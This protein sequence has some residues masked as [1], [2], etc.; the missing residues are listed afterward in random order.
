[1]AGEG[2]EV[3]DSRCRL[4]VRLTVAPDPKLSATLAELARA[5]RLAALVA[6]AAPEVVEL[7]LSLPTAL[8]VTAGDDHVPGVVGLIGAVDTGAAATVAGWRRAR[9]GDAI[10]VADVATSRHAA[11]DAGEAGADAILFR[12]APA[13]VRD[14]VA[15][16][17]ELFVLP[18]AAPASLDTMADL[19][20]A[21]ADFLLIEG[22]ELGDRAMP[23]QAIVAALAAAE[24]QRAEAMARPLGE[25]ERR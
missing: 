14:C 19:V 1:M 23:P 24:A 10:L 13:A 9:G 17:S 5:D 22:D 21:G 3:E 2:P 6:A 11:M 7:A 12:G 4:L 16:W 18:A 8:L 15:W 25:T 20:L